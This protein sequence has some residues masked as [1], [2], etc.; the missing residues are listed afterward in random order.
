MVADSIAE[1]PDYRD[2]GKNAPA[3]KAAT[4]RTVGADGRMAALPDA[5]TK[6]LYPE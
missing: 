6:R 2:V 1:M 5:R 3:A 4:T